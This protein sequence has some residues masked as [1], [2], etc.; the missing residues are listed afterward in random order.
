MIFKKYKVQVIQV[1]SSL[2]SKVMDATFE[3]KLPD[4]E[5]Y[6]F[7]S[8]SWFGCSL[9]KTKTNSSSKIRDGK[10][11]KNCLSCCG[12]N[13]TSKGCKFMCLKKAPVIPNTPTQQI[14]TSF[15]ND[16]Q[17]YVKVF[18][19]QSQS[20][21]HST[22]SW[23]NPRNPANPPHPPTK[24]GNGTFGALLRIPCP[25]RW[26]DPSCP[27]CRQGSALRLWV[28]FF[29]LVTGGILDGFRFICCNT[30]VAK[31]TLCVYKYCTI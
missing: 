22:E 7:I 1:P 27:D 6:H 23:R 10:L 28:F 5:D 14:T 2:S 8:C 26:Q 18:P 21:Y 19:S 31:E 13:A 12:R 20:Y 17:K 11:F 3:E 4:F 16:V 24:K 30:S 29:W 15:N 25:Q 9:P